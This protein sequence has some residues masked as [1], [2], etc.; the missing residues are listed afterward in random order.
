MA[1]STVVGQSRAGPQIELELYLR[2]TLLLKTHNQV[3]NGGNETEFV[4]R[5][6]TKCERHPANV[7]ERPPGCLP[8]SCGRL[9]CLRERPGCVDR[10][11]P[12]ED[13]RQ[14]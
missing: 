7:L 11:E 8:Q 5:G 13:G 6:R 2:S 4:E 9:V 1:V 12:E 3:V 14:R 10:G